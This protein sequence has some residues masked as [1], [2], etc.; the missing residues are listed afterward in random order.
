M[1]YEVITYPAA[2]NNTAA[3]VLVA[4]VFALATIGTMMA[5][6]L[7]STF[8]LNLLPMSKLERYSHALAGAAIFMCG[9]A[10]QFL[11]L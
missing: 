6:V 8:G 10:I 2:K 5:I 4:G 7:V 3:I 1:L 11:G 9:F